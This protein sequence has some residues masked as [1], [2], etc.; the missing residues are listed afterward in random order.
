M[1]SDKLR[2]SIENRQIFWLRPENPVFQLRLATEFVT[3]ARYSGKIE[4]FEGAITLLESG[5]A[6]RALLQS[7]IAPAAQTAKIMLFIVSSPLRLRVLAAVADRVS[8]SPLWRCAIRLLRTIG[9]DWPNAGIGQGSYARIALFGL[10]F[11][12]KRRKTTFLH[13]A[14]YSG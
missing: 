3:S 5:A 4:E 8:F 9:Y 10:A 11:L 14:Q 1:Y 13:C 7:A 6:G 12:W 2:E